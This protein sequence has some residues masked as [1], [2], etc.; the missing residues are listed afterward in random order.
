MARASVLSIATMRAAGCGHVTSATWRIPGTTMSAA[1]R[2]FPTTK[3]R[4]SRTRRSVETK[5]NGF[6]GALMSMLSWTGLRLVVTA[7]AFG[8]ERD[9]LDDLR[10]ACAAADVAGNRLDDVLARRRWIF[11]QHC[12]GREDHGRSA[13]T[14][15][16]AVRLAKRVLEWREFARAGREAFDGRDRIAI[17]LHRE[18]QTRT[19]RDAVKQHGA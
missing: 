3:R 9:C 15:L 10:I 4:S 18:H 2:P 11:E 7:H 14:A 13:I 19:H 8:R 12:V 17:G 16:H 5:R 6:S 1:K